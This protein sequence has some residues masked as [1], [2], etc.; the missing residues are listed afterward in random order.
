MSSVLSSATWLQ[1]SSSGI[2]PVVPPSV[3]FLR[4]RDQHPFLHDNSM[5]VPTRDGPS[6]DWLD[7]TST[8]YKDTKV[9]D[10]HWLDTPDFS[11]FLHDEDWWVNSSP[12]IE[13]EEVNRSHNTSSR[14]LFLKWDGWGYI[15]AYGSLGFCL[16][17]LYLLWITCGW[18]M[19]LWLALYQRI[20][21]PCKEKPKEVSEPPCCSQMLEAAEVA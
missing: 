6:G 10:P 19:F 18:C 15:G 14:F 9:H 12:S 11:S 13:T 17:G 5:P 21:G 2:P 1:T 3:K 16:L 8:I 20:M 7:V 4:G